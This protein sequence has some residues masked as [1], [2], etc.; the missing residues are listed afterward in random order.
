MP[1]DGRAVAARPQLPVR[2]LAILAQ[3]AARLAPGQAVLYPCEEPVRVRLDG[4]RLAVGVSLTA[5]PHDGLSARRGTAGDRIGRVVGELEPDDRG[6]GQ[7]VPTSRAR[8][9]SPA[10]VSD[11]MRCTLFG[12]YA[13]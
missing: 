8:R 10:T 11:S 12:W 3:P 1:L 5:W 4:Y 13:M 9:S 2:P 7:G 6:A